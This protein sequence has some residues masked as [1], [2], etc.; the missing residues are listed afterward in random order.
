MRFAT[1]SGECLTGPESAVQRAA[2]DAEG[3]APLHARG[4]LHLYLDDLWN[5]LSFGW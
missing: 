3:V 5:R 1:C 4:W 2:L